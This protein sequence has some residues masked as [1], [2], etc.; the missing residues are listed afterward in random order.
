[1]KQLDFIIIGAQ[2]SATTSLFK[3]LS[4][5]SAIHMPSD[6]E[7]PFFSDDHLYQNGWQE[8]CRQYFNTASEDKLWGTASPQYMGDPRAAKRIAKQNPG[9]RLIAI[10]RNPIDR[11]Y[12]HYTMSVRREIEHRDFSHT[13]NDL[14]KPE[15]L[16]KYRNEIPPDH[17]NGYN[18]SDKLNINKDNNYYCV[19]S[20]YGRILN[21]FR[22]YFPANQLLIIYMDELMNQPQQSLDKVTQFLGF[23]EQFT[24]ANLGKIYHKGGTKLIIPNSW[25]EII[26]KNPLFRLFWDK[27]PLQSKSYINYWYEQLNIRKTSSTPGPS[28]QSKLKLARHFYA[29]IQILERLSGSKVPWQEFHS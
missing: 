13:I 4:E 8:F 3:Y 11:A 23:K 9:A 15:H 20:E 22:K 29:D 24:P 6:K 1:M 16:Q 18:R 12:S 7:A 19:W 21:N 26:K 17:H 5:H 10:L 25:K 14:L 27:M 2:K 28:K